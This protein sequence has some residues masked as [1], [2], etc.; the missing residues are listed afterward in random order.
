MGQVMRF[1]PDILDP[2]YPA[3]M[4]MRTKV[5]CMMLKQR[6]LLDSVAVIPMTSIV[7]LH[8]YNDHVG[9]S[10]CHLLMALTIGEDTCAPLFLSIKERL[11]GDIK[12]SLR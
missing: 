1:V 12:W 7:G 10:L 9:H 4:V 3:S 8:I 2:R 5:I 6:K 11:W